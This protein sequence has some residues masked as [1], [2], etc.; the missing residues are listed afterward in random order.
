MSAGALEKQQDVEW[1]AFRAARVRRREQARL[2]AALA[3]LRHLEDLHRK[4]NEA[5]KAHKE[6]LAAYT[7]QVESE[8]ARRPMPLSTRLTT[9]RST[10]RRLLSAGRYE[11]AAE[12]YAMFNLLKR[13]EREATEER[14]RKIVENKL[15]A[16]EHELNRRDLSSCRKVLMAQQVNSMHANA[17]VRAVEVNLQH[18]ATEMAMTHYNQRRALNLPLLAPRAF[19]KTHQLKAARGTQLKKLVYGDHYYVP[20]LCSMYEG[21]LDQE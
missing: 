19:D 11:E 5:C 3:E 8:V 15:L 13:S 10:E 14:K 20:S 17:K 7:M 1:T 16:K 21:F 6:E 12:A 9:L 4:Y 2:A 18:K